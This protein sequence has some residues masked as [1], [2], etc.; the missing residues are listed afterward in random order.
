MQ[1]KLV[2]ILIACAVGGM[3]SSAFSL[4]DKAVLKRLDQLEA[5]RKAD[6]AEISALRSK[7]QQLET[8]KTGAVSSDEATRL[9]EEIVKVDKKNNSRIESVKKSVEGEREKLKINGYMSV[10]G[11]KSTDKN[12]TLSS[13]VDNHIGFN[14]DTIAGIQFDYKMDDKLDAVVQLQAEGRDDY[15]LDTPWAF[16]RYKLTPTTSVRAGRM[17]TPLYLYADSIDVGYTYP[18]V[19]PPI[20]MYSVSSSLYTGVDLIQQFNFGGWNNS[21]Q[22]LFGDGD[23]DVSGVSLK[24]DYQ[25]GLFATFNYDAWTFRAGGSHAENL[26]IAGTPTSTIDSLDYLSA[27][28]RYDNGALLVLAEARRINSDKDI[29]IWIPDSDG[30]YTTV[31]YQI[32]KFMP[33]ATWAKAYSTN[34][35]QSAQRQHQDSIGLG[36]RYNLTNKVVVKGEATKYDHFDGTA[37]VTA[38]SQLPTTAIERAD[39]LRQLDDDGVTIM[40]LGV[41]AIF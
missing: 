37:G 12:V 2:S 41:D 10:Y 23:G 24:S 13:G 28:L 31:G 21:V 40:S 26:H 38:F 32:D 36:L 30:F 14:S 35:P 22:V 1:R 9:R 39:A 16:L 29:E 20:E 4:D 19:R 6:Q 33:Y 15:D 34:E 8:Q 5:Q 25:A 11:V 17:V 18:W 3:S 27:S 7:V